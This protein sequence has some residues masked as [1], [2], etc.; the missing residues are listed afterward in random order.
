MWVIETTSAVPT[1]SHL[2]F[3]MCN[4]HQPEGL[5]KSCH[6]VFS[7]SRWGGSSTQAWMPTYVSILR[8]SKM[9][10]VWKVTAEWYDRGKPKNS[11]RNLPQCHFVHHKSHMDWP[12]REPGPPRREPATNDLNHGAALCHSVNPSKVQLTSGPSIV[13]INLK[14]LHYTPWRCLGRGVIAPTHSWPRH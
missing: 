3:F 5:I 9:I 6:P 1:W 11:E 12:G 13:C 10:W 4:C 2:S 14:L 7:P 8:I